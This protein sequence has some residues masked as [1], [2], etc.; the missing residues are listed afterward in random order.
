M[1]HVLIRR[2][3]TL[4]D[5]SPDG[6][7][8][9]D[10]SI[11]G[12]LQPLLSY[13]HKT[14]LRGHGRY[15]PDGESRNIDI[16]LRNMY[17]LEQ[18]RLVTGFGFLTSIVEIFRR[19]GIIPHYIDLSPAKPPDVYTPDWDNV[20]RYVEFRPKQEECLWYISQN[21]CG[22]IDATMGFG[23]T[24][25]FE[26]MCHL[27][28]RA[29]FAIGVR[30][31]DVARRITRQLSRTLPNIGQVGGNECRYGDRITIY[32]AGSFH[33]ARGDEDFFLGDEAHL[34]MADQA[35]RGM[36]QSW[37]WS[38]NFGWTGTTDAR[39]DGADAQMELFFGRTIFKI[40]Y[41]EAVALGLVVPIHVRW[42]PINLP[43]NPAANK[44]GTSKTRW[45]IW[46][47]QERNQLIAQDIRNNYP[48]PNTQ[49]LI[50]AATV[51]HA[52]MLWQFLPDFSLCYGQ[53]IDRD[54]LER[55]KRNHY[56]PQNFVETTPERREQMRQD[57][58]EG[59]LKRVIATDV[60]ATGVDFAQLQVLY[61]VDA[62][63]SEILDA[64]GPARVSRISPESGKSY[65]EVIDCCDNWDKSFRRKSENR[66]RHYRALGWSQDWPTGR[67][68]L[69]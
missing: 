21:E 51:E 35:A 46:R 65:G 31:V 9:L 13:E 52:I 24:H 34:L 36:A 42:I 4:L 27:Y 6:V 49:I 16:E 10:P 8:P 25:L 39:L 7:H 12:L 61:R 29:K 22:T 56:L 50:L 11:I 58:E 19:H 60:W 55:Y 40:T 3:G 15:G 68:R 53:K 30:L 59:K 14:L 2:S 47:H 1:T 33:K 23:K 41:Q 69:L 64:Q 57:F 17:S 18:G 32:T 44:F 5:I 54:D 63:E 43:H 67:G 48:D 20:R 26:A 38:R 37:R 62:R 28:P 66:R 45:G